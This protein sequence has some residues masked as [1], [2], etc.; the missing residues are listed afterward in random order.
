MIQHYKNF[1]ESPANDDFKQRVQSAIQSLY[2]QAESNP[3]VAR[4]AML[5]S[6]GIREAVAIFESGAVELKKKGEPK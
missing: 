5:I 1:I 3:D 6:R 2:S 4:D